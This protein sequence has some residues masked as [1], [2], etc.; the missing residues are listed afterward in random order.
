MVVVAIIAIL[1]ALLLPALRNARN[2]ARTVQCMNNMRQLGT[3]TSMYMDENSEQILNTSY[4]II[5]LGG[6]YL[7]LSTAGNQH[8]GSPIWW[9]PF[10]D[11]CEQDRSASATAPL[12]YPSPFINRNPSSPRKQIDRWIQVNT[13]RDSTTKDLL[14]NC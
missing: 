5:N 1:A 9:C 7:G 2:S 14:V 12:Y 6:P 11:L 13:F 8:F 4:S 10:E 3:I